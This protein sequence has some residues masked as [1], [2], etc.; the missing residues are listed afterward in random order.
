MKKVRLSFPLI[1]FFIAICF[2]SERFL[3]FNQLNKPSSN[4]VLLFGGQSNAGAGGLDP[5]LIDD[6][7]FP[8]RVFT[9]YQG[10]AKYGNSATKPNSYG[11]QNINTFLNS[12]TPLSNTLI[13]IQKTNEYLPNSRATYFWIQGETESQGYDQYLKLLKSYLSEVMKE[14]ESKFKRGN[15]IVILQT[16]TGVNKKTN[17][18]E[19]AQLEVSKQLD[20]V[21]LAG[22]SYQ[23]PIFDEIHT[24]L[25]R[26]VNAF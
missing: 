17:G 20:F 3:H 5:V 15:Q 23:A 4:E 18:S 24:F 14:I 11:G 22:P 10:R 19:L 16:N 8:D 1:L 2:C 26:K 12:G 25:Y 21:R 13:S 9:F 7:L 6:A